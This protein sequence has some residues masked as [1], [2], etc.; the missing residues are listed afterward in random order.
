MLLTAIISGFALGF[1]GS[2]HCL[3]MC[4]P[5]LLS[6]PSSKLSAWTNL[7]RKILYHL[8]RSW[9]Y[10][11]MGLVVGWFGKGLQTIL[12]QNFHAWISMGSGIFLLLGYFTL[13][14]FRLV[15][16][17]KNWLTWLGDFGR[18]SSWATEILMGMMNA[19][20]PCG[21]VYVALTMALGVGSPLG[22]LLLMLSFGLGTTPALLTCSL[23][24]SRLKLSRA[25]AK[26]PIKSLAVIVCSS[27]LIV[28]GLGLGIPY[29][30]PSQGLFS[31]SSEQGECCRPQP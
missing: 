30:S 7:W 12:P 28:R 10:G 25:F 9:V 15:G 18:Q 17:G 22:A 5:L 14:R 2:V 16:F 26:I 8:A 31:T 13:P 11:M 27:L 4:G 21:M 1:V 20:L 29:L 23:L 19:L 3:G 6:L 24:G